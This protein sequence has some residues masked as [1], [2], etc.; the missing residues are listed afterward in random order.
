MTAPRNLPVD[1]SERLDRAAFEAR[2]RSLQPQ[3]WGVDR[4]AA[5]ERLEQSQLRP[6]RILWLTDGLDPETAG[7]FANAMANLAPLS[8]YAATPRGPATPRVDAS[9]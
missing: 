5:L 4:G 6:G 8:I 3:P 7:P 2:L 9:A 1:P